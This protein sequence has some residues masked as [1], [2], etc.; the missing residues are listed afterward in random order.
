VGV[1][2]T[3]VP[4]HEIDE[5]TRRR[6]EVD[7]MQPTKIMHPEDSADAAR[8]LR[9]LQGAGAAA[10]IV[11]GGTQLG[12]GS[13]P[14]QYDVAF[15]TDRLNHLLEYEPADLTCRVEAGMRLHDLQA[16]LHQNGQRLPFAPP[17]ADEATIGGIVAADSNG[18][19]RARYGSVRDWVIGIAVA[20]P[21]GKVGR[22]GGKVV[23]NVAGYDLMKLHTGALGTLGVITEVNLK[24]QTVPEASR[25][26]LAGFDQLTGAVA[27]GVELAHRYL[28]PALLA[29]MDGATAAECGSSATYAFVLAVFAEGYRREVDAGIDEATRCILEHQGQVVPDQPPDS[30]FDQARDFGAARD[31]GDLLLCLSAP[32][33]SLGAVL[34]ELPEGTSLVAQPAAGIAWIRPRGSDPVAGVRRLRQTADRVSGHAVLLNASTPLK[35]EVD[36]WGDPPAALPLMRGLKQALDPQAV[37]NPGRFVGGL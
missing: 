21:D 5:E 27:A 37:C 26:V 13:P 23:K 9:L 33:A 7:G 28:Q 19:N 22:A 34:H 14:R 15:S 17:R 30:F 16:T 32:I 24:V 31:A 11:G 3:T 1:T 18:L 12:L 35:R 8:G 36:V 29:V 6:L 2:V 25:A 4:G 10:V 20:Y